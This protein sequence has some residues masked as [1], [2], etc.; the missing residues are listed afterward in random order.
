ALQPR[1]AASATLG[2]TDETSFNRKAVASFPRRIK[3]GRNRL[4]VGNQRI[5]FTQGSRSGNPGLEAETALRFAWNTCDRSSSETERERSRLLG[6]MKFERPLNRSV[7]LSINLLTVYAAC[8]VNPVVI[9]LFK[10][11]VPP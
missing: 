7:T 9:L 6:S 5:L 8:M 11:K 4:A 3:N 2:I 10:R 1:V